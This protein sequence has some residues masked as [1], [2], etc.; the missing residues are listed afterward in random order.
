MRYVYVQAFI[1]GCGYRHDIVIE[2]G[3]TSES[4]CHDAAFCMPL[5]ALP[6]IQP[7]YCYRKCLR[8]YYCIQ[9]YSWLAKTRDPCM[10]RDP[11]RLTET[12]RPRYICSSRPHL[13]VVPRAAMWPNK[14]ESLHSVG[15]LLWAR[16]ARDIDRL[17]PGAQQQ[18]M[19]VVPRC[20]RM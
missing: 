13:A 18:R 8:C 3:K 16:Q 2:T 6:D 7:V 4:R 5:Y 20:Q 11:Q 17:L 19:R 12:H 9:R 14:I 15:L 1:S 10:H